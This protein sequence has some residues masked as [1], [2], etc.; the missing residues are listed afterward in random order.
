MAA[1]CTC[2][3]YSAD[4][5]R[6]L[7]LTT[8]IA[9]VL[10]LGYMVIW[11]AHGSC[12]EGAPFDRHADGESSSDSGTPY[13]SAVS[14]AATAADGARGRVAARPVAVGCAAALLGLYTRID[15]LSASD[16]RTAVATADQR[17]LRNVP[18][19]RCSSA[20]MTTDRRLDLVV[21]NAAVRALRRE[22]D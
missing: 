13:Q 22:A 2:R 1:W 14:L 11:P 8:A 15:D 12:R 7:S 5:P 3:R 4:G 16:G 21:A 9:A 10:S 19:E 18:P 17:M 20:R 6:L